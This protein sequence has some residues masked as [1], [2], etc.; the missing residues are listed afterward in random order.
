[1]AEDLGGCEAVQPGGGTR[2]EFVNG[3]IGAVGGDHGFEP[4]PQILTG[5]PAPA[6]E[7]AASRGQSRPDSAVWR[8]SRV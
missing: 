6:T 3:G 2:G 1:M 5:I 8:T 4:A 7:R